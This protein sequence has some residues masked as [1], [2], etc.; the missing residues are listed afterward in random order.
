M[1]RPTVS[2]AEIE[3]SDSALI[4]VIR[5][6]DGLRVKQIAA[7][8]G[9]TATAVRQ[10]LTRL[11]AHGLV[12]RVLRRRDT[13]SRGRPSFVYQLTKAGQEETGSNLADL[14][15]ALWDEV[16]TIENTEIRRGL[17]QRISDRLAG[18]YSNQIV[19]D[20]VRAKME[21]L[22][23]LLNERDIPFGVET[24]NE[25][26]VLKAYGCPYTELAK[27]DRTVCSMERMMF[28]ELLGENLRLSGC[29]LD[30]ESCCTFELS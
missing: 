22:V 24:N 8:M 3:S 17:L 30:G 21:S 9:V 4:D 13:P 18:F 6:E 7:R 27:K 28:A 25:L 2:P 10:R 29:R 15:V 12:E 14:A 19:G 5:R 1:P 23:G 11:V 26:P 16:R 20:T